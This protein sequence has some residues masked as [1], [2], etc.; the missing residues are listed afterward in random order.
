MAFK[1]LPPLTVAFWLLSCPNLLNVCVQSLL[2]ATLTRV[3]ILSPVTHTWQG[4][5]AFVM[6]C[7]C[8]STFHADVIQYMMYLWPYYVFVLELQQT[9]QIRCALICCRYLTW[10]SSADICLHGARPQAPPTASAGESPALWSLDREARPA[11]QGN[12]G[13]FYPAQPAPSLA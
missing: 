13:F 9:N 1:Q 6:L 5:P 8:F 7:A 4:T 3:N 11:G 10:S 2:P 12:T